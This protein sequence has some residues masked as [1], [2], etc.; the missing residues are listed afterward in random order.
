MVDGKVQRIY[1]FIIGEKG[2]SSLSTAG[3][4]NVRDAVMGARK[5]V[6]V[7]ISLALK[8]KTPK[9]HMQANLPEE[10]TIATSR[11]LP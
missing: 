9:R 7:G 5:R 3:G 4:V 2:I 1:A 10:P 6:G 8:N 11:L